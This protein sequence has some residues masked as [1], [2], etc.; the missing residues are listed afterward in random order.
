M[1]CDKPERIW[2]NPNDLDSDKD[3]WA[4]S[5]LQIEQI[6]DTQIKLTWKE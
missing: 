4:P 3:S 2:S 6:T 5:D 1:T